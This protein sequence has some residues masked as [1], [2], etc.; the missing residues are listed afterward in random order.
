MLSAKIDK[1]RESL[2]CV[3]YRGDQHAHIL[4]EET[5]VSAKLRKVTL[6]TPN[7]DWISINPDKG[8]GKLAKMSPLL[9][10]SDNSNAKHGHHCACDNVIFLVRNDKLTVIYIDLKSN[11]PTGYANQF[12]STRQFVHYAIALIEE[13]HAL[14]LMITDERYIVLWGGKPTSLNKTTTVAKPEKL[15]KTAPDKAYKREISNGEK[16]Y[17]KELLS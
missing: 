14:K 3:T 12:K 11:N 4:I 8:R 9:A 17:L 2:S 10:V 7:G 5:D 15:T 16:I 13:F 1:L 6:T